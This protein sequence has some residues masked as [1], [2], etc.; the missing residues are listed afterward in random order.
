MQV[1]VRFD[2]ITDRNSELCENPEYGP[3][4]GGIDEAALA[5]I[6][7]QV[8]QEFRNGM[9]TRELDA[10]AAARCVHQATQNPDFDWLAA[11]IHASDLHR[12]TPADLPGMLA[13]LAAAAPLPV[14]A[15]TPPGRIAPELAAVVRRAAPALAA[16]LVPARDFRFRLFGWMT[17]ALRYLIRP[18]AAP[19]AGTPPLLDPSVSERPQHLYMRVALGL[20][21]CQPDGRGHEAPEPAFAA[22]LEAAFRLYDALSL[23][24]ISLATPALLNAGTTYPQLA[25]CFQQ[26]VGDDLGDIFRALGGAAAESK[27]G[28]GVS[29]WLHGVRAEG[30]PIASSGGR[31]TGVKHLLRLFQETQVYVNQG[32]NRPGAFAAYLSVDHADVLTFLAVARPKGEE[33]LADVASPRLKY[34]LWVPDLFMEALVAEEA[35]DKAVAA[36]AAA[37]APPPP[38]PPGPPYAPGAPPGTWFLFSPDSAPG[39]HLAWGAEYRALYARYVAERRYVRAVTAG[40]VLAEAF[41]TWAVAGTPYVLFKDAVNRKSNMQHVAPICSSNLCV[42]GETL[43]LTDRGHV[44]IRALAEAGRPVR[45]W[46]GAEWSEVL[47]RLTAPAAPLVRVTVGARPPPGAPPGDG[48]PGAALD[49]TLAHK[50]YVVPPGGGPA[51]ETCA[52]GLAPGDALEQPEAWPRAFPRR[53]EAPPPEVVL[54]VEHLPGLRPTYCFSEPLRHRGVFNGV[55]TGQCAEITI[56]SWSAFDAA[57]F[58]R[59]HPE[60]GRGG[61]TGVCN[62][63]A[64]CLESF[65]VEG[66]R[67]EGAGAGADRPEGAG[68]DRPEGA[69]GA[70]RLDFAGLAEAAGLAVTALDAAIDRT[71]YPTEDCRRSN[72][73]HRPVGVGIMGL[74]DVLARLR[75]AFG[76]RK[77]VAL[78]RGVAAAV[79]FGALRA[80]CRLARERGAHPSFP[81]SPLSRG[82]LA[83]DLWAAEAAEAAAAAAAGGGAP[84]DGPGSDPALGPAWE[85]EVEAATGGAVAP[86]DWAALRAEAAAGVRNAYVTAYMPTATTSNIVGQ[87]ECFEPF[88]SNIYA[89]ETLAGIFVVVNRHL[90][91][92]LGAAWTDDLRRAVIG[93][94]GSVQ[95]LAGIPPDVQRRFLTARELHPSL[96]T[97]TAKAMAPFVCQSTSLNLYLAKPLLPKILRF[98]LENWR[99]GLKTGVYYIHTQPASGGQQSSVRGAAPPGPGAGEAE[100]E[101]EPETPGPEPAPAALV[102]APAALVAAPAAAAPATCGLDGAC[103]SCSV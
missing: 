103:P 25:S 37:G 4:L 96:L 26:A 16:R 73:R 50:F 87:N 76:G 22:R 10:A 74:A 42:A 31:S 55:L 52:R 54:K 78:A 79:Y 75:L 27:L 86:A 95:G 33:A 15:Q 24:L 82:L 83:P 64:L 61:E 36:A 90:I 67:H 23:Q 65:V 98:L 81:G 8:A 17:L 29:A 93:A 41:K 56:P 70:P 99:A 14:G 43:V 39:L 91:R 102:A 77:A 1:R 40:E 100:P 51:V 89:R 53:P 13:A 12:R 6:T 9:T 94:G 45:V 19:P 63:A 57:A 46:N 97:R 101:A 21:V 38:A 80:S 47:P 88:T 30:A 92:E 58:A 66:D 20:L 2:R 59:F 84:G 35:W 72:L 34:A 7:A 44:P 68:V 60:N 5:R 69:A 32:G 48:A 11:R 71:L 85:A 28:G 18:G 62:L 49:C 3:P